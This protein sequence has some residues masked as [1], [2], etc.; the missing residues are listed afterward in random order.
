MRYALRNQDKIK[1]AFNQDFLDNLINSL[2]EAFE[3]NSFNVI[4]YPP[5]EIYHLLTVND[6]GHA[7]GSIDFYIIGQVYDVYKLAYKETIN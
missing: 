7:K 5:G 2:N 1:V 6:I 3:D 4:T